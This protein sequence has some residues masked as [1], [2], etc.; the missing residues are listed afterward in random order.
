M[1][2]YEALGV[3]RGATAA[4][5]R[6]AYLAKAMQLDPKRFPGAPPDVLDAVAR[7]ALVIDE[8]WGVLGDPESRKRYDNG[9]AVSASRQRRAGQ[10]SREVI[11]EHVWAMEREVGW[12]PSSVLGLDPPEPGAPSVNR[13]SVAAE[14]GGGLGAR[15][16]PSIEWNTS[17]ISDP[18][19]GLE[20]VADWLAPRVGPSRSVVVPDVCGRAAS[21]VFYVVAR[22]DLHVNFVALTENPDGDGIVVDQDPAAG[23]LVRRHSTVTVQAVYPTRAAHSS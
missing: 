2:Y 17:P 10:S 4:E 11:A 16:I 13:P 22:A 12:K 19:E 20:K 6:H 15:S 23:T 7:A 8:A 14:D 18:L 9:A 1:D 3:S 5:V 21:E